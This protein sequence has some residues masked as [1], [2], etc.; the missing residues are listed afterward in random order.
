MQH[1]KNVNV[2]Y[3]PKK[4]LRAEELVFQCP[5][6]PDRIAIWKCWFLGRGENRS[7]RRKTSRSKAENQQQTQPTYRHR[8]LNP[9]HI[10][11]RRALSPLRHP[12]S[13]TGVYF[14]IYEIKVTRSIKKAKFDYCTNLITD[15]SK[16]GAKDFW[17]AFKQTLSCAKTSSRIKSAS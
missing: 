5:C 11:G 17:T 6:V 14:V 7:T 3:L 2:I 4:H 12:C 13:P 1:P 8:G 15:S 16:S 10:G 9:G